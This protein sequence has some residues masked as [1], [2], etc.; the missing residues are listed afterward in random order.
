MVFWKEW[1]ENRFG[2]L[3]ALFFIMGLYYAV[4]TERTL[5]DEY[6]LGIFLV[7]FGM[8]A[9]IALGSSAVAA[10]VGTETIQ[11]LVSKPV[12]RTRLLMAKYLIRGAE[13]T[14]IYTAPI[15]YLC[16]VGWQTRIPWAW[17]PPYLAL[18]YILVSLAVIL[19]AYSATF[20]F[21]VAL[22][23]QALCALAG[24]GLTAL[25]FAL[26]GMSVLGKVYRLEEVGMEISILVLLSATALAGSLLM[27]RQREF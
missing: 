10:E 17:S 23:K 22:R 5:T 16:I 15:A 3:A 6:W 14:L 12:G 19:F 11:F 25:Y 2:F 27:F 1:R 18:Q 7:F 24:I 26:R 4:P 8:A 21:S 9:A 13:A 20:L